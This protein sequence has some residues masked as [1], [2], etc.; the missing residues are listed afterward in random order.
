MNDTI[1]FMEA[2]VQER[3][4]AYLEQAQLAGLYLQR[5]KARRDPKDYERA[6]KWTQSSLS[7]FEN[8]AALLVKADLL[9]SEHQFGQAAEVVRKVIAVEAGNL[10]ARILAVRIALA[11]GDIKAAATHLAQVPD[12]PLS[13]LRFLSGQVAEA[14]GDL[15]RARELYQEAIQREGDSDSAAESA[16]YR[17]VLARLEL[18]QGRLDEAKELLDAAGAIPVS[19]PLTEDLRARLLVAQDKPDEAATVLRSAYEVYR[20]PVFLLRLG[21]LQQARGHREEARKTL[22]VAVKLLRE[23]T[24]GHERDLALALFYLDPQANR[25]EIDRLMA[26][27][28]DRRKDEET[29]RIR[30]L[31]TEPESDSSPTQRDGF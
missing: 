15:E 5:A 28:L 7:E 31:V 16:R 23:E 21:E 13:S 3:P 1:A 11:Q 2:R 14:Q 25:Q 9:Q 29:L 20:D 12:Q 18:E 17:G 22:T 4:R 26:I 19:Q 24:R 30:D 27:E 10:G 6:Q 8:S